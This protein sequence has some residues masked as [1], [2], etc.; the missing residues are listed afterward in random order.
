MSDGDIQILPA[1]QTD[2]AAFPWGELTWFANGALGN[3]DSLTL[4]RCV[5]KEGESNPRHRHPNCAEILV[6]LKGTIKHTGAGG[7]P[8]AMAEGDVVT[9]PAD[10]W[11]NAQNVGRGEAVLLIAFSSA[12]R[13]T[14]GE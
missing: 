5:L 1:G 9:I 10:V 12:Y 7:V 11:H 2:K 4:G 3:C 14:I 13:E 8:V 6:V